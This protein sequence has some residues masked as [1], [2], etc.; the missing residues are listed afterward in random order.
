[1]QHRTVIKDYLLIT[2]GCIMYALS[3]TLF[4]FPDGLLLGGTSGISVILTE[5][6]P[7]SPG[8]ILMVINFAL[9]FLAFAVLG[10]GMGIKTVVGSSLTALFI[11]LFEKIF[12]LESAPV[13]NPYLAAVIGAAIIAIASGILFYVKANSGG[14][15]IVA[16]IVQKFSGIQIG[17]ALLITDVII[18][19]VGGIVSGLTV[20]LSSALG[21]LVKVLGIDLVIK[22]IKKLSGKK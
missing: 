10:L 12:S 8:I 3:T 18:V 16:L 20:F 17:R 19:I 2:L 11:G 15:D 7:F 22:L 4:I 13:S 1:M 14:T 21:F 5:F 6:L 9:I